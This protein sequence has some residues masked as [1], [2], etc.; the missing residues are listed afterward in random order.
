MN[1]KKKYLIILSIIF[2]LASIA[3]EIYYVVN[4]FM[5][6]PQYR[7]S[8]FYLVFSFLTIAS[9]I[10]VVVLLT[11]AIWGNGKYFRQRY[12]YYMTALV[13]SI[14][15]DTLSVGTILLIVT[16]FL[17]DWEWIKPDID[18][19]VII[20]DKTEVITKSREEKIKELQEMKARGEISEEEFQRRL[21]DLL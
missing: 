10:A 1:N 9:L 13:I 14:I 19:K 2:T 6:E 3:Y 16:M 12:G 5:L 15:M 20:D 4:W 18:D 11:M 7:S 21:M 8:T 17:S